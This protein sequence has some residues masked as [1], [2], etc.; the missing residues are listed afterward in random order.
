MSTHRVGPVKDTAVTTMTASAISSA[1]NGPGTIP[2]RHHPDVWEM[3][4]P[5]RYH[6]IPLG[7]VWFGC[8]CACGLLIAAMLEAIANV[9]FI[10][11][12]S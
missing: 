3:V 5:V 8:M 2:L 6:D 1:L 4:L 7:L 11:D 10:H 9:V 12:H